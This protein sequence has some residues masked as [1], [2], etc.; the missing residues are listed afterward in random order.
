[1]KTTPRSVLLLILSF[2][3]LSSCQS[4]AGHYGSSS[5]YLHNND[6]IKLFLSQAKK[7]SLHGPPG[8][9]VN[10][11]F[12]LKNDGLAGHFTLS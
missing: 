6:T 8:E 5:E 9:R 7:N 1:M 10:L 2:V 3:A 4:W 12:I 11:E